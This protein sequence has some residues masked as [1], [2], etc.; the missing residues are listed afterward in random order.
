MTV[1]QVARLDDLEHARERRVVLVAQG[2]EYARAEPRVRHE[3]EVT[4]GD[5]HAGLRERHLQVLDERP[6]ERPVAVEP[7]KLLDGSGGETG[8]RAEPRRDDAPR[9]RPAEDPRDR[10]ERLQLRG[11][12]ALGPRR[13]P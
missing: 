4:G 6:E 10:P 12:R 3:L 2:P 9:L 1:E 7:A 11:A 5:V 8:A 13:G